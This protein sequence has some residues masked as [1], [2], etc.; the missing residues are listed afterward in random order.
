[1]ARS[2]AGGAEA[3]RDLLDGSETGSG[4]GARSGEGGAVE[5]CLEGRCSMALVSWVKKGSMSGLRVF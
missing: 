2:D 1:M 4:R 3:E 5:A